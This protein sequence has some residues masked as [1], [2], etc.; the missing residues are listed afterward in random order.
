MEK[1]KIWKR[2]YCN[3]EIYWQFMN[4]MTF[5]VFRKTKNIIS[6]TRKKCLETTILFIWR[7]VVEKAV[8]CAKWQ[9]AASGKN[10]VESGFAA[11]RDSQMAKH[12]SPDRAKA[13][14]QVSMALNS[15]T[16]AWKSGKNILNLFGL[17]YTA[18][19]FKGPLKTT[20][21]IY[22]ENGEMIAGFHSDNG[23]WNSV[24]TADETRFQYESNQ[25]YREAY[26]AAKAELAAAQ[27]SQHDGTTSLDIRA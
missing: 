21:E 2:E 8:L 25:I 17:P 13:T 16:R 11:M 23:F 26:N 27:Q 1:R 4:S 3:V 6:L 9:A 22:N 12:I 20:A 5:I 7:L 15:V 18:N 14:S 24:P 10:M 19:V